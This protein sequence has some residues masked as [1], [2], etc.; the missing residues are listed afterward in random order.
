MMVSNI[1]LILMY[2]KEFTNPFD[3]LNAIEEG[4]ELRSNGG[5]LNSSKKV[6]QDVIGST[7]G[8][9]SITP[10]VARINDLESQMIE[11]KLVLL[12]SEVNEDNDSEV[13]EVY[14]ETATYMASKSFNVNKASKSGSGRGKKSLYEQ[15][16][17]S[18]GED[19]HDDDFDNPGLTDAQM[20]FANAFDINLPGQL[21]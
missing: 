4:N 7:F 8:I 20:Q 17:E 21:I 19:P 3:A 14:D 6:V 2:E 15:W 12:D 5:S 1:L 13:D 9:P 10:F 16:Q 11:G 18:H